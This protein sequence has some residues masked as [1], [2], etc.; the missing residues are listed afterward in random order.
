MGT[1][2]DVHMILVGKPN[3]KRKLGTPTR[4]RE[5]NINMES[6]IIGIGVME[7]IDL[8]QNR[9]TWWLLLMQQ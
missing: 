7:C 5:N 6:S 8:V 9:V 4:R 3:G 1:T 2:R